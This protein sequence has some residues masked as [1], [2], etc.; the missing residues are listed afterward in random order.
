MEEDEEVE[1]AAEEEEEDVG[2]CGL[3]SS[4]LL[5]RWGRRQ[6]AEGTHERTWR[7]GGFDKQNNSPANNFVVFSFLPRHRR[8]GRQ[9]LPR[10]QCIYFLL[11]YPGGI[12]GSKGDGGKK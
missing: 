3:S 1:A 7:E 10:P 6:R 4:L 9:A 5:R 12:K 8:A 2:G 11:P